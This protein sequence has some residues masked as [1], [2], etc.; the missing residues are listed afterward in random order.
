M[1]TGLSIALVASLILGF[2]YILYLLGKSRTPP[3]PGHHWP[4][5]VLDLKGIP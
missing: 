1:E 5:Y 4:M 2:F 3:C